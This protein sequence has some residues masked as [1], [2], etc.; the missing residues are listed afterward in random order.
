[1]S[2]LHLGKRP[3]SS[4]FLIVVTILLVV[5]GIGVTGLY[6]VEQILVDTAGEALTLAAA[7]VAQRLDRVL[8]ERYGDIEL[9]AKVMGTEGLDPASRTKYLGWLKGTYPVY[10]WIG[11]TDERGRVVAATLPSSVGRN[12]GHSR[13]FLESRSHHRVVVTDVEPFGELDGGM[14]AVAFSAGVYDAEGRFRGVAMACVSIQAVEEVVTRTIRSFQDR[15]SFLSKLEY[16][17]LN[18]RGEA[19]VDSDLY[20]KGLVNLVRLNLPSARLA[21]AGPPGYVEERHLRGQYSVITGFARTQGQY[22]FEGMQWSVLV[23]MDKGDLL[24][25]IGRLV[26]RVGLVAVVL[27]LPLV[28]VLLWMQ[29]RLHQKWTEAEREKRRAQAAE[30]ALQQVCSDLEQHILQ[31]TA[32]LA[33]ANA[34]LEA[35]VVER[36]Q[37]ERRLHDA[38]VGLEERVRDRTAALI[39]QQQHLRLLSAELRRTEQHVRKRLATDLHD[40]LAQTLAFCKMKLEVLLTGA[41]RKPQPEVLTDVIAHV[42]EA[43]TSTRE[44]MYDLRPFVL[45]DS[46]DVLVAAQWVADKARRHG[47][48]VMVDD[49]GKSKVV[50]EDVLVT[51]YQALHEALFNVITHARTKRARVSLRRHRHEVRMVIR[52]RGVGFVPLAVPPPSRHGQFGLFNMR[53]QV[54]AIGGRLKVVSV[55]GKGTTLLITAPLD[56]VACR[57]NGPSGRR[58]ETIGNS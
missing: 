48:H 4:L 49:D 5:L 36:R 14:D 35:E 6:Y 8:F 44:L 10:L 18:R 53:E 1:M 21:L 31:R 7:E 46:D 50:E 38:N 39:M 56:V 26:G 51:L 45:G 43:L 3:H 13:W 41:T 17:I 12:W 52:D 30:E 23:R 19:F 47:L 11:L 42:N 27:V 20:H 9:M 25:P 57:A 22:G 58:L 55:V 33:E 16:Q 32:A 24:A 54:E 40:N 15:H 28:A 37:A 29:Y 2:E 34:R